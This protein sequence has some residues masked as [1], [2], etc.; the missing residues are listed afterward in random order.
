MAPRGG[1]YAVLGED[2]PVVK[3][4]GLVDLEDLGSHRPRQPVGT[5]I[6]PG[7]QD[8]DLADPRRNRIGE[9]SVEKKRVRTAW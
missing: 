6:Q 1:R 7:G 8:H 4:L 2:A 3:N 5:G 9:E